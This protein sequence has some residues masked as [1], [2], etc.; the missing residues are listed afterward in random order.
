MAETSPPDPEALRAELL[1]RWERSAEAW[2]RRATQMRGFG[3]P[4]ATWLIEHAGLQPGQRVLELAGGPGETG[5][6]AAD[7]IRPGGVLISSDAAE[8]MLEVA[9]GRARELG[10]ENV[11]FKRIRPARTDLPTAS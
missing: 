8:N 1:D 10:I 7:L 11:E 6:R 9:R 2:G 3:M 5:L 4:V